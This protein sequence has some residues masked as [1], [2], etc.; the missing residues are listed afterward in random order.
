[1]PGSSTLEANI[2]KVAWIETWQEQYKEEMNAM[3]QTCR[4]SQMYKFLEYR[5]LSF[6]S[7]TVHGSSAAPVIDTDLGCRSTPK[8]DAGYSALTSTAVVIEWWIPGMMIPD[9]SAH[10]VL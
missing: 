1:M 3:E 4:E 6:P 7:I 10:S 8:F 2:R 9:C 5:V